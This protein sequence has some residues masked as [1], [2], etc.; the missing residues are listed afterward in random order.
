MERAWEPLTE[1]VGKRTQE[2]VSCFLPNDI[3]EMFRRLR[4]I[5]PDTRDYRNVLNGLKL[6]SVVGAV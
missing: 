1:E 6:V 3:A 4:W 5:P 2:E